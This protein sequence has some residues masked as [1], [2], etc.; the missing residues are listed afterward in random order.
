MLLLKPL[1]SRKT[2]FVEIVFIAFRE[3]IMSERCYPG[4]AIN[5]WL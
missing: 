3:T 1:I 5:I 4:G 2:T